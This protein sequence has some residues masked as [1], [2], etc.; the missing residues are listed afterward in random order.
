M[1]NK[2]KIETIIAWQNSGR[3]HPF[4]CGNDSGHKP[5]VPAEIDGKI[6]LVC[7]DCDYMQEDIPA[8]VYIFNKL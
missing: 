8:V 3:F 7:E 1:T 4:T 6:V 5:L 2:E